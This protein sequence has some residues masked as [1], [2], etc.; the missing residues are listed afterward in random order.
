[1]EN[2]LVPDQGMMSLKPIAAKR[3]H[4]T[5]FT[6]LFMRVVF[7]KPLHT[8]ARHA[9]IERTH[10]TANKQIPAIHENKEQDLEREGD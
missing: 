5:G 3:I 9:L 7:A 10:Q 6:F 4:A 2:I 1:M 8:F